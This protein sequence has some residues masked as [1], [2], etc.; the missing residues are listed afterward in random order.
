MTQP[1][2]PILEFVVSINDPNPERD[3][4][5]QEHQNRYLD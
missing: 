2:N 3:G 5:P 1:G 4:Y